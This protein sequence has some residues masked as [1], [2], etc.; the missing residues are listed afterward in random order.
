[1]VN[2]KIQWAWRFD[3]ILA[4]HFSKAELQRQNRY[5]KEGVESEKDTD[6]KGQS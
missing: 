4:G 3:P 6:D 5:K 2:L 1:M